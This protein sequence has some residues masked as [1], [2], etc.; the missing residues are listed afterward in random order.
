LTISKQKDHKLFTLINS[1]K[2]IKP[3]DLD[4]QGKAKLKLVLQET[5]KQLK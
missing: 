5:L 2:A 4:K 3:A 1:L